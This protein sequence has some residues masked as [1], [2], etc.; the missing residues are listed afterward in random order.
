MVTKSGLF[1]KTN[2]QDI[3]MKNTTKFTNDQMTEKS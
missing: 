2:E 1:S 3:F